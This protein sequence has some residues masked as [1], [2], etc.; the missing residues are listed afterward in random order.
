MTE[1]NH[2]PDEIFVHEMSPNRSGRHGGWSEHF[3]VSGAQQYVRKDIHTA[4]VEERDE[5][6]KEAERFKELFG[7]SSNLCEKYVTQINELRAV[8]AEMKAA[9]VEAENVSYLAL[10]GPTGDGIK[11]FERSALIAKHEKVMRILR[12]KALA[13]AEKAGV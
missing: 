13:A 4:V 7:S 11:T 2:M 10:Q 1:D 12:K 5:Y 8:A 6:W 9:I 3:I